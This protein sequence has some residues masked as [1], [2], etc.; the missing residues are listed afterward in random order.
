[1]TSSPI[2]LNAVA[3]RP[4]IAPAPSTACFMNW[5]SLSMTV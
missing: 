3:I 4:P 5:L 2:E 1:V